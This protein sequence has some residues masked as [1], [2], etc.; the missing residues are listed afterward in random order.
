MWLVCFIGIMFFVI[1]LMLR[2]LYVSWILITHIYFT[3]FYSQVVLGSYHV[4]DACWVST[5]L[6]RWSNNYMPKG[7]FFIRMFATIN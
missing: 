4:W 5:I 2:H 6:C 7:L 3:L 1:K